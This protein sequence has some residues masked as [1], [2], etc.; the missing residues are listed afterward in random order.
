MS[1]ARPIRYNFGNVIGGDPV[2]YLNVE[3][4][5]IKKTTQRLLKR[6]SPFGLGATWANT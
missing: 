1:T 3:M 6:A 2:V 4:D 5:L